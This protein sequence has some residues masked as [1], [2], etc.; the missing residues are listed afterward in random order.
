MIRIHPAAEAVSLP[1][2]WP[3]ARHAAILF[4][5]LAACGRAH[6]GA[7]PATAHMMVE[8]GSSIEYVR[9]TPEY[10]NAVL[11]AV[12]PYISEVAEKLDLPVQH[13]VTGREVVSCSVLPNRRVEAAVRVRGGWDFGF[14]GGYV[15]TI[16]G[17]HCYSMLQDPDKIAPFFGK[18]KMS[19][20]EAVACARDALKRL[21]I[22]LESVFAEQ[23]PQVEGPH[24]IGTNTV[25]HYQVVWPDPR[26]GPSVEVEVDG[27]LRRLERLC[28]RNKVLERAPPKLTVTP[29]HDPNYPVW[30]QVN[31]E[32][33]RRLL[34]IALRAVEEY[35]QTLSLSLPRRLT[36]NEVARF[37]VADNG[38]WPHAE[39]EL[40]NGWRFIYR[41]SM[42]NGFY[43]PDNLFNSDN[44]PIRIKDFVGTWHMTEVAASDL[45][46]RTLAKLNYP[47][48]LIHF[49]V[50]PQVH[51]P[52]L[53]GIPRYMFYWYYQ[54][55]EDLDSAVW[56]EVD[57]DRREVKS[58]YYDNKAFWNHPPAI[59]VPI[60]LPPAPA[61]KPAQGLPRSRPAVGKGLRPGS[62]FTVPAP[63]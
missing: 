44:R 17:P 56:A 45:V 26:G 63:R 14:K 3:W 20:A 51:R 39:I 11:F 27:N 5:A 52:A 19:K 10:S 34:P 30:P 4:C 9:V 6:A 18:L 25:P 49:E 32:Y 2:F 33:A 31:P 37:S 22:P 41:N 24:S 13:P 15:E 62:V 50:T 57:A 43:A 42:V 1:P 12:L 61:A 58:L 8:L 55:G 29:P 21:G 54:R 46:R 59:D 7:E 40:S 53:A 48:N 60:S 23:E 28:L 16:Q 38:G 36:T 35:G 47:T